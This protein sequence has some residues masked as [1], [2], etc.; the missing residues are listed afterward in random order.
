MQVVMG[1][2]QRIHVIGNGATLANGTPQEIQ[3]NRTV[4][5]AYLGTRAVTH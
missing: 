3:V 2:C 1:V 5:E 4:I